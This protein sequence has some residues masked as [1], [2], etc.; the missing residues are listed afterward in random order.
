MTQGFILVRNTYENTI[1]FYWKY[2]RLTP[3][4]SHKVVLEN[5]FENTNI[6]KF[7]IGTLTIKCVQIT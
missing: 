1:I 7:K 5:R 6:M 3:M 2:E 4:T